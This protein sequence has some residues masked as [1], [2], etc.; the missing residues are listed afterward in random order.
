MIRQEWEKADLKICLGFNKDECTPTIKGAHSIQNN[1][2]LNK[3]SEGGHVYQIK[4]EVSK[5]KGPYSVFDKISRNKASTFFGFCDHHDTVLFKP[6]ELSEYE[7]KPIQNFLFAFRASA[8]EYHRKQ[9]LL[10]NIRQMFTRF[11]AALLDPFSVNLYRVTLLDVSDYE[12]DYNHFK[13]EYLNGEFKNLRTIYR[14]LD[15][16][17]EFTTSSAF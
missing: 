16:E 3:I 9:R 10:N 5:Q 6:I 7:G 4:G 14:T 15:Y 1:R 13:K 11:P 8:L 2:F 17:V 12:K